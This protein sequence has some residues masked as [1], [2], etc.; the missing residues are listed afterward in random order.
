MKKIMVGLF[1]LLWLFTSTLSW[2]T[3]PLGDVEIETNFV[4][5]GSFQQRLQYW[6]TSPLI[7]WS[8]DQG[9]DGT[10]AIFMNA[11]FLAD[12]KTIHEAKAETCLSLREASL[13]DFQAS[14]KYESLPE[15]SSGHRLNIIWFEDEYC[16]K[17]GQFGNYVEPKLQ[18]GWQVLQ[19]A[20]QR[21][22]LNARSVKIQLAQNQRTSAQSVG[23]MMSVRYWILD[24]LGVDYSP[25]IAFGLWDNIY[26]AVTPGVESS[27]AVAQAKYQPDLNERPLGKNYVL[28]SG[29]DE[30]TQ[31]WRVSTDHQWI[32]DEG[33]SLR[34]ALRTT[35]TSKKGSMGTGVFSQCV[36]FG[37]QQQFEMGIQFKRLSRSTQDGGG[38]YRPTWYEFEN[39]KGRHTISNK[40]ADPVDGDEWQSLVITDLVPAGGSRSV[41]LAGIQ[42]IQGAGDFSVVWDDAYFIGRSFRSPK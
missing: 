4:N 1:G 14:F 25:P 31:Q 35:I 27:N 17:G 15:I 22:A 33:V 39:C 6:N 3:S 38:R 20:G 2:S 36:N 32:S 13:F 26:M 29:F 16:K 8:S 10:A 23:V 9:E 34:G 11:P 18:Y 37:L 12:K 7:T 30:D 19:A 24:F 40:H 28:N 21:A 5:N 42:V 41:K